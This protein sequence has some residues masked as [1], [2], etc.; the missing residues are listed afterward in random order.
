MHFGKT[1]GLGGGTG[2]GRGRMV[3]AE[4]G[5]TEGQERWC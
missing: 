3:V 2:K 4:A 1:L 5:L